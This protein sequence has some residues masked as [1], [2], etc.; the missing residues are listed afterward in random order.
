MLVFSIRAHL[1]QIEIICSYSC[2][3]ERLV[4]VKPKS[5]H[6]I[7]SSYYLVRVNY[8]PEEAQ[9]INLL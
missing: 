3:F 4:S 9:K 8:K 1:F 7:R 6:G 2:C 5:V